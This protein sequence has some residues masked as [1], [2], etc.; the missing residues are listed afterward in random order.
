M[1]GTLPGF[2]AS[3]HRGHIRFSSVQRIQGD[4]VRSGQQLG[5]CG[6]SGN[7]TEPH[8]HLQV[9]DRADPMAALGVPI[10]ITR[11]REHHHGTEHVVEGGL[12]AEGSIIESAD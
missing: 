5:A 11:F 1:R 12:P 6:N 7:S 2:E 9:M 3:V 8:V 10:A 4:L